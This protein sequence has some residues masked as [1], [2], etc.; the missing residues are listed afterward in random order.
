MI[1]NKNKNKSR[2]LIA[3]VVLVLS[4][5][6]VAKAQNAPGA[7]RQTVEERKAVYKLIG[8]NF[9]PFGALLK[10]EGQYDAADAK[11]R[12]SREIFLSDL[13]PEVFSDASNLGEPDTKA[14][15]EI[16]SDRAEFD[17]KLKKFQEDLVA[18]QAA[19][20][21]EQSLSEPFKTALTTVAQDCKT[22]HDTFRLK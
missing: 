4:S 5:S 2:A 16:W 14:K 3:L 22:C 17:K 8:A 7:G 6:L 12:I 13:I 19:N 10:G 21:K 1:S 18:L 20:D 11:K 15:P 9:R